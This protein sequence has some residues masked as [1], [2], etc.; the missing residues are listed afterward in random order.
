MYIYI[1]NNPKIYDVNY[2]IVWDGTT[3]A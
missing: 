1:T 3:W 2:V